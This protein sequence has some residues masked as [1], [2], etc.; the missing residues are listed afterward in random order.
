MGNSLIIARYEEDVNWVQDFKNFN[1]I[2]YNKGKPLSKEL[3]FTFTF[4]TFPKQLI[5]YDF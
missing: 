3:N 4:L 1:T 2:I 5:L